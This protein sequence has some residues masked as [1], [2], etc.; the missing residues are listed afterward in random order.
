MET[1]ERGRVI[2]EL[3]VGGLHHRLRSSAE[4]WCR[5]LLGV[6]EVTVYGGGTEIAKHK[7]LGHAV[8]KSPLE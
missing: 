4:V 7:S 8:V 3:M 6:K 1:P 5:N 2:A